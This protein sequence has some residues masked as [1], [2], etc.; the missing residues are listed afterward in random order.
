VLKVILGHREL[1][2]FKEPQE[3]EDLQV[4]LEY[5][6]GQVLRELR[7]LRGHRV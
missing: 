1:L 4:T 6:D 5:R 2:G 7:D 3:L